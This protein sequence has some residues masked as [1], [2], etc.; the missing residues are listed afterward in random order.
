MKKLTSKK[1]KTDGDHALIADVE[2]LASWYYAGDQMEFAINNNG[3]AV[4]DYGELILPA[5]VLDPVLVNGAKKNK[6]G[7]Q[8]QSGVWVEGDATLDF[9]LKATMSKMMANPNLRLVTLERVGTAKIVRTRPYL[10]NW[11]ASFVVNYDDTVVDLPQ[12][13]QALDAAG[14]LVGACERRP[15]YGRFS[16]ELS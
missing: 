4:G 15:R 11:R 1:N 14:R 5:H 3:V 16:Y 9:D 8:F 13:E 2:W 10:K 6:L 7:K 12:I